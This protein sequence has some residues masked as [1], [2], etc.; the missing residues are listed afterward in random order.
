MAVGA[1]D[2]SVLA[3]SFFARSSCLKLLYSRSA[4]V[5]AWLHL[6]G[7]S[8]R[9]AAPAALGVKSS[10]GPSRTARP[11]FRFDLHADQ[12]KTGRHDFCEEENKSET[13]ME[14]LGQG[15]VPAEGRGVMAGRVTRGEQVNERW[16]FSLVISPTAWMP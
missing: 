1:A 7:N 2:A 10:T 5:L 9:A 16:K 14:L 11:L 12:S 4:F 6:H 8:Q 15:H 3:A 13:W